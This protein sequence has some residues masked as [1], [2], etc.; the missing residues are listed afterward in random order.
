MIV[1]ADYNTYCLAINRKLARKLEIDDYAQVIQFPETNTLLIGKH[2]PF[3]Q[4]YDYRIYD[5]ETL[6]I[7]DSSLAKR[8]VDAYN[9]DFSDCEAIVCRNLSYQPVGDRYMAIACFDN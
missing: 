5:G 2:V 7:D 6:I 9:L 8:I 1:K 3:S 4:N